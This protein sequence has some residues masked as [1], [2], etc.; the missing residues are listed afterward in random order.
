MPLVESLVSDESPGVSLWG[1]KA[2]RAV[3]A[4]SVRQTPAGREPIVPRVVESATRNLRAGPVAD[5]AFGALSLRVDDPS[6]RPDEFVLERA[7]PQVANA[8]L[9]IVEARLA[10]YDPAGSEASRP[11]PATPPMPLAERRAVLLLTD[12]LIWPRLDDAARG[13]TVRVFRDAAATLSRSVAA[14]AD[15][16]SEAEDDAARERAAQLREDLTGLLKS[17]ASGFVAIADRV[18]GAGSDAVKAAADEIVRQPTVVQN[19]VLLGLT[20]DLVAAVGEMYP[21]LPPPPGTP[22]APEAPDAPAAPE[23]PDCP[24][25]PRRGGRRVRSVTNSRTGSEKR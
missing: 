19:D 7:A 4:E 10:L 9:D 22:E 3:L 18:G 25:C 23:A 17:V 12:P 15:A 1:M 6:R 13:R 8:T 20:D 2:A 11:L 21:D 5:E 16:R 14:A 24:R